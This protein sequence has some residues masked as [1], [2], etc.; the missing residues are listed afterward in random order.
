MV[1]TFTQ[2]EY[3]VRVDWLPAVPTDEVGRLFSKYGNV[4]NV[5][6]ELAPRC[7]DVRDRGWLGVERIWLIEPD[8]PGFPGDNGGEGLSEGKKEEKM[9]NKVEERISG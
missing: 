9:G 5:Y 7:R 1:R 8:V 4:I 2:K 6:K 3:D